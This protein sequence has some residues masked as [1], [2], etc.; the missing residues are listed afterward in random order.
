MPH[1]HGHLL[2]ELKSFVP[3]VGRL[4]AEFLGEGHHLLQNEL[5]LQ[6]RF[7]LVAQTILQDLFVVGGQCPHEAKNVQ[8]I[9]PI[10]KEILCLCSYYVVVCPYQTQLHSFIS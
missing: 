6:Q 10:C 4:L 1:P 3:A 2:G 8:F 7:L 5:L 9:A